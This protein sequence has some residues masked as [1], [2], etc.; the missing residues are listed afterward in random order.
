[1]AD[2]SAATDEPATLKR[3][4]TCGTEKALN[5]DNFAKRGDSTDG[6]RASC[7]VCNNEYYKRWRVRQTSPQDP[8][9]EPV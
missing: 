2:S 3:C 4:S 1:M 9:S 8:E 5:G 6:W 7:R